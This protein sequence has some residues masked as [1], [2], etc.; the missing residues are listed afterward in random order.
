MRRESPRPLGLQGKLRCI[1]CKQRFN[2]ILDS[3]KI[4]EKGV[5]PNLVIDLQLFF[6]FFLYFLTIAA[7]VGP[8]S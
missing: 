5:R 7:L 2:S 8:S 6:L 1:Y 3:Q 4:S